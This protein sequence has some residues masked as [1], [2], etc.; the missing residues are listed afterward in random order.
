MRK[1]IQLFIALFI[2]CR[3]EAQSVKVTFDA[4]SSDLIISRNIY[5]HFAEHLGRCIYDGFW[6]NDSLNVAKKDRLRLDV[7]DALKKIKIPLL[8]WPGGCFADEYHWSDGI[9][10]RNQRPA[11]VNSN[12]GMVKEDNSFGTHEFLELC[13][14]LNCEPYIAGNVGSGTTQEM[15]NWIEYLNYDGSSTL[16][17]LRRKNGREKPWKVSYWGVGNE[18]WGCGGEM[19]PEYYSTQFKQYAS[20]CKNY[21]GAPLRKI[22]SGS[23]GEDYNW[24]EVCMKN[25]PNWQ[26]WGIS[27]H[28]YTVTGTWQK[29]GSATQFAEDEYFTALK[30]CLHIEDLINKHSAIMDKYDPQKK[31]ALVVDEWG[32][33]TD[34]EPGANAGIL[35][36]QNSMRDALI[37]ASTLNIFNNHCDRVKMANLAQIVNVLQS[38]ILTNKEKMVLTPTYYVFDFYKVHQDSKLLP[39]HLSS[40]E[41]K[42]GNESIAAINISASQ[43]STGN[44]HLTIA[45]LDPTKKISINP[46][47]GNLKWKKAEARVLSSAKFTDV[48]SFTEPEKIKPVT[49]NDYKVSGDQ[50]TVNMPPMSVVVI[51][52]N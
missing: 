47:L 24:T 18:S 34:P 32:I 21:P 6:V 9:G 48:N 45:N 51:T 29:K 36:Q 25:I 7:I 15:A 17:D 16:A 20:F 23:N 46:S 31:V 49:F 52:L 42:F 35:Y 43:D 4:P 10:P 12:W 5:G 8:R 28:Y 13:T 2:V 33:W 30:K 19:T 39:V 1:L 22:A 37:A 38:L 3:I 44:I 40:P 11:R 27:M 26:M 41:Y 50:L 14:L